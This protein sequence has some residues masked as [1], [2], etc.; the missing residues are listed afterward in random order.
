MGKVAYMFSRQAVESQ[1]T[2]IYDKPRMATGGAIG[3]QAAVT[4]VTN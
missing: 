3:A 1:C 4:R 2:N